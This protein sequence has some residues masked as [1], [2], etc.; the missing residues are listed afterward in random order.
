MKLEIVY[1]NYSANVVKIGCETSAGMGH[2][3]FII[4]GV[5]KYLKD[6]NLIVI[7]PRNIWF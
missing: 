3:D 6:G 7:F 2:Y 5:F 4:I 1:N